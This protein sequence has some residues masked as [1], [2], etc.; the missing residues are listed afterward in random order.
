M[1]YIL[2]TLLFHEGPNLME[3]KTM[4]IEQKG[5]FVLRRLSAKNHDQKQNVIT[6]IP[7]PIN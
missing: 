3:K 4:N 5:M 2:H 6:T 7:S 1:T